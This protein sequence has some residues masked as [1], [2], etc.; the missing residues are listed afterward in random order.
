MTIAQ[1]NQIR[2][3][4]IKGMDRMRAMVLTVIREHPGFSLA[5]L[6]QYIRDNL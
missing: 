3:A 4:E 1:L 2:Q 5:E 6:E